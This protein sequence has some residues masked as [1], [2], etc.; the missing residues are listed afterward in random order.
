MVTSKLKLSEVNNDHRIYHL[1]DLL[2]SYEAPSQDEENK[3]RRMINFLSEPHPYSP[4]SRDNEAGHITA[5]AWIADPTSDRFLLCHHPKL[6]KWL[7]LGGHIEDFDNNIIEAATRE[8]KEESGIEDLQLLLGGSIFDI[9]IHFIP[10]SKKEKEHHHYDIR[11]LFSA[12]SNSKM[13]KAD[14]LLDLKWFDRSS[15]P[16]KEL[17][18]LRMQEKWLSIK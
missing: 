11:F 10:K 15:I 5:S 9:D 8:A 4:L 16:T 12:C 7:Q 13:K 14:E 3:K 18:I 1:L 17:S 2:S 6:G